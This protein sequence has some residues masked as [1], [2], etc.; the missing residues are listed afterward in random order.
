MVESNPTA[1]VLNSSKIAASPAGGKHDGDMASDSQLCRAY[2]LLGTVI[3]SK[4]SSDCVPDS[5][6]KYIP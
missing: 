5:G 4:P 6:P 2:S 1:R 3:Q